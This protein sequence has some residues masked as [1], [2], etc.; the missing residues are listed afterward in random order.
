MTVIKILITAGCAVLLTAL[1]M[2]SPFF[3]FTDISV[4]GNFQIETDEILYRAGLDA[5]TNFFLFNTR[6]ARRYI[7]ENH[8]IE[9]VQF[10]RTFPD[11][12]EI[13]V[14]ERFLSGFIEYLEGTF[15]YIDENGRLLQVRSYARQD[16]PR[17]T[18]LQP[19]QVHLGQQLEVDDPAAF[20]TVMIYA[21]LLNRHGLMDIISHIDISDT[22]NIRIRLYNIEVYL[23]N[24]DNAHEKILTLREIVNEWPVVSNARGFLDLREPGT[25]FIFRN[26][27]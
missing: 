19:A 24:T 3:H 4:E 10:V 20:T 12:I 5:E 9:H 7:K 26:L 16:L 27:T 1:F 2:F 8:F 13:L 11:T 14:Q 15:L 17:I 18:G 6:R 25:E 22:E 23:G 21:K